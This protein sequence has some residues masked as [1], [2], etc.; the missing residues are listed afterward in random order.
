MSNRPTFEKSGPTERWVAAVAALR[1]EGPEGLRLVEHLRAEHSA[2]D[3]RAL[4][5]LVERARRARAKLDP[6][7]VWML[8]SKAL[9][10]SSHRD[11]ARA[12]ARWIA[13]RAA[14]ATVLDLTCGGGGDAFELARA[15]LRV[16]AAER[17]REAAGHA[18]RNLASVG[19]PVLRADALRPPIAT[20]AD[21]Y[22]IADPDRRS[23]GRRELDPAR[24]SPPARPLLE[25][26][27]SAAGACIKLGP[28]LDPAT[29]SLP[30]GLD[31]A[32]Q[33]VAR[34]SA[35]GE[36]GELAL[37]TG[38]LARGLGAGT[39]P[40]RRS[41]I[42]VDGDR[43]ER[44]EGPPA[45]AAERGLPPLEP[46]AAREA[47]WIAE[48][49]PALLRSGLLPL[50]AGEAW[51]PLGPRLGFLGPTAGGSP[52]EPRSHPWLTLY[53]IRASAPLDRKAVRAMLR[54]HDVGPLDVRRRGHPDPPEALGAKYGGSGRNR[55]LLLVARLAKGPGASKGHHAYLVDEA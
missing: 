4:A 27:A 5:G 17:D 46:E 43:E 38:A 25:L 9:E 41:L 32:W 15:G 1:D 44:L 30:A 31:H 47:P 11:V 33:W 2:E 7:H 6:E 16:V 8:S 52:A 39:A 40:G 3:A 37:W 29:L 42:R 20:L 19:A 14:G 22:L 26:C 53:R 18:R 21:K 49:H 23:S 36:L 24:W 51:R 50:V 13:A 34:G 55:G 54:E 10:Q 35:R 48:G 12:R 45:D 28:A